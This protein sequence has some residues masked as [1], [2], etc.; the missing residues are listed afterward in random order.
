M[1]AY[2]VNTI[3]SNGMCPSPVSAPALNLVMQKKDVVFYCDYC[4]SNSGQGTKEPEM[5]GWVDKYINY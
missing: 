2:Y 5:G 1:I 3:F 4:P